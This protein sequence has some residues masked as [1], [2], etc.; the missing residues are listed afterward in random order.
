MDP[1]FSLI[2]SELNGVPQTIM[3][4]TYIYNGVICQFRRKTKRR[5]GRGEFIENENNI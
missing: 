4:T 1:T 2:K 3:C 5:Q